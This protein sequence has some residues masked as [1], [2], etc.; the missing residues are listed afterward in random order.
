M[1]NIKPCIW[2]LIL[3]KFYLDQQFKI[4]L[5]RSCDHGIFDHAEVVTIIIYRRNVHKRIE[6]LIR[7]F[8]QLCQKCSKKFC[9]ICVMHVQFTF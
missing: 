7:H 8:V 3:Q 6:V 4:G 2:L 1:V 5:C 9:F